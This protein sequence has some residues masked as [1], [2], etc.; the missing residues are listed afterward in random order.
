MVSGSG[1]WSRGEATQLGRGAPAA[2]RRQ[3]H[4]HSSWRVQI[5][6]NAMPP[7]LGLAA[8]CHSRKL[9]QSSSAAAARQARWASAGGS[10]KQSAAPTLLPYGPIS[11][12]I[13]KSSRR[14][15]VADDVPLQVV[16][17]F[18]TSQTHGSP[19]PHK[20]HRRCLATAAALNEL[21]L[22]RWLAGTSC[23]R[24]ADTPSAPRQN[25]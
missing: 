1:S 17:T 3:N 10:C 19:H 6:H 16:R 25:A 11:V 14:C 9:H 12:S 24:A 23:T 20:A 7:L 4:C 13:T 5:L 2:S 18:C 15:A 8:R 22:I 21:F